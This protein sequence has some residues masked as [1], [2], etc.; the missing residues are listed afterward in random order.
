MTPLNNVLLS[1]HRVKNT[2]LSHILPPGFLVFHRCASHAPT[3][4]CC[5]LT[6]CFHSHVNGTYLDAT[7]NTMIR[8]WPGQQSRHFNP[9]P[10]ELPRR[11]MATG[12]VRL[13]GLLLA[14]AHIA[15]TDL[16]MSKHLLGLSHAHVLALHQRHGLLVCA[17]TKNDSPAWAPV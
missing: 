13:V 9:P 3:W 12:N 16:G 14:H 6:I 7:H 4:P 8:K 11:N 17:C 10:T 5:S 15:T 1:F 2:Q